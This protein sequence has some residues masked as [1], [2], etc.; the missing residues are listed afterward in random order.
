[1]SNQQQRFLLSDKMSGTLNLIMRMK[2]LKKIDKE[3]LRLQER[4]TNMK[5]SSHTCRKNLNTAFSKYQRIKKM[6]T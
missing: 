4:L 3:N 2:E 6:I 1:M 5:S